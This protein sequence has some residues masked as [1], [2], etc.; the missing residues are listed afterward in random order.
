M[1]NMVIYSEKNDN[2]NQ[3]EPPYYRSSNIE[4]IAYIV[5]R[6]GVSPRKKG[7]ARN[8]LAGRPIFD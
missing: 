2:K 7:Q 1:N 3:E 6:H 4:G 5:L 8:G